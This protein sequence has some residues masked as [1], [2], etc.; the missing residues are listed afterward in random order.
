MLL[1]V[2]CS[3]C[4]KTQKLYENRCSK[5]H[6]ISPHQKFWLWWELFIQQRFFFPAF[7][8]EITHESGALHNLI[9]VVD[10]LRLSKIYS[11][12]RLLAA[13]FSSL[14]IYQDVWTFSIARSQERERGERSLDPKST[15]HSQR[16][17]ETSR[18]FFSMPQLDCSLPFKRCIKR[19]TVIID[20]TLI[21]LGIMELHY[22][23]RT[24][25]YVHK[26]EQDKGVL[27]GFQENPCR[28][29]PRK[30][31]SAGLS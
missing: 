18:R 14:H 15:T 12:R 30:I 2:F 5:G 17:I 28:F 20:S 27:G 10:S 13:N 25:M 11:L 19:M 24:R 4:P 3:K 6:V 9:W 31:F 23:W 21:Q 29:F 7:W 1:P 16:A 8:V 22:I 26:N